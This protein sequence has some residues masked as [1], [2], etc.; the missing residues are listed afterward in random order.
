MSKPFLN[1][2]LIN[3]CVIFFL[4]V[5]C[6]KDSGENGESTGP[7]KNVAKGKV[8]DT[9]GK[10]IKGASILI[11]N[12]IFYN[13]H[14]SGSTGGDG[15]YKIPL[16]NGAWQAYAS[17]N[18]T[19]NGKT[20]EVDL[21]PDNSEGF[22][23]EGAVRNFS[24]KL[25]GRKPEPLTGV[26]GG[27]ILVDKYVLSTIYDTENIE[28]TLAPVGNLIDGSTG[29]VIRVN[30]GASGSD[31]EHKLNDLPIGRYTVTA[32]Y[33]SSTGNLP[34][35]LRDRIHNPSGDFVSS[36]QLDFEPTTSNG[37]NMAMLEFREN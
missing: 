25:T 12:T 2:L 17:I 21:H 26:Y 37:D 36:L 5:S 19:Y 9:G 7:E 31:T 28:F 6:K 8:T 10:P 29:Q 22:S 30:L 15:T 13:T 27:I 18:V 23:G 16:I 11:D 14:I 34:I 32:L 20:Y 1:L 3:L 24:W 33:H 4:S 35:K